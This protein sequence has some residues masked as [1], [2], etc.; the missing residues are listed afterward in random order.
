MCSADTQLPLNDSRQ[1]KRIARTS[2]VEF[3]PVTT[4]GAHYLVLMCSKLYKT[5]LYDAKETIQ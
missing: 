4:S 1:N 3:D 5:M 2:S